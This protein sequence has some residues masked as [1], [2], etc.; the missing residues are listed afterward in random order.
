MAA[1][2]VSTTTIVADAGPLIHLDELQAL[3]LLADFPRVMVPHA[4]W[5][6]VEHHRPEALRATSPSLTHVAAIAVPPE[7]EVVGRL[8]TLHAGE[9][10][11]LALCS[12][13]PGCRLLTDDTAAR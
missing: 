5:L 7:L 6:E 2:E 10:E 3:R 13:Y 8:Y 11:A 1:T 4:V 12:Q 9:W